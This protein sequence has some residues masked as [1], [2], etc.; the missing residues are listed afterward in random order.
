MGWFDWCGDGVTCRFGKVGARCEGD[1]G[2]CVP[3]Y[4]HSTRSIPGAV[5][6]LDSV[7]M[8]YGMVGFRSGGCGCEC[9]CGFRFLVYRTLVSLCARCV[10]LESVG[11]LYGFDVQDRDLALDCSIR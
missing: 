11:V 1:K 7:R 4:L 6:Y 8:E 2:G 3:G 9:E 5:C 10:V